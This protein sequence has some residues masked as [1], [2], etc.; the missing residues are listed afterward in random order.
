MKFILE[1]KG[2]KYANVR[3][4]KL[5]QSFIAIKKK[6]KLKKKINIRKLSTSN[7]PTLP[8][9]SYTYFL[10]ISQCGMQYVKNKR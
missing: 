5:I 1:F 9:S 7:R 3:Y 2:D 10:E 4:W 6:S 8:I